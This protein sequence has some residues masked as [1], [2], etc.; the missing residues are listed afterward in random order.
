MIAEAA[1]SIIEL[2]PTSIPIPPAPQ[3]E[4]ATSWAIANG[5]LIAAI[6]LTVLVVGVVRWLWGNVGIRIVGA[7][8]IGGFLVYVVVNARGR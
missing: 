4:Q 8:I 5:K 1:R 3:E 6:I 7:A 2:A